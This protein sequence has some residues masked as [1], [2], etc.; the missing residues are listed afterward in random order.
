MTPEEI[1]MRNP[2]IQKDEELGIYKEIFDD[3]INDLER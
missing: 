1:W 2:L 3:V